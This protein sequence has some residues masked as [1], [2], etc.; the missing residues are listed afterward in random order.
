MPSPST[1]AYGLLAAFVLLSPLVL[2]WVFKRGAWVLVQNR[3]G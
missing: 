3:R 2:C 1:L